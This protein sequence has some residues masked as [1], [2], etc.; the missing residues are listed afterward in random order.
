MYHLADNMTK[1][2]HGTGRQAG[3]EGIT[4]YDSSREKA[5]FIVVCRFGDLL[6]CQRVNE[7]VYFDIH[8]K[9]P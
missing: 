5:I 6:V 7:I 9:E 2:C 3:L 8:L 4:V 1:L